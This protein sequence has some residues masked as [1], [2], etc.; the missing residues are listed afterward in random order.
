MI[1]GLFCGANM[2]DGFFSGMSCLDLI[3]LLAFLLG[4][5]LGLTGVCIGFLG[6]GYHA[7]GGWCLGMAF[8]LVGISVT[9][10]IVQMKK[11]EEGVV[12][13]LKAK[14]DALEAEIKALE[15]RKASM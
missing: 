10:S 7:A 1:V 11:N 12:D 2:E 3:A 14:R 6:G 5:F 9:C 15:A 13:S 8:L 4:K